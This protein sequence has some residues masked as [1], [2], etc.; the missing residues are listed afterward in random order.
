MLY[1]AAWMQSAIASC[2]AKE[3]QYT[4]PHHE[5]Q[6]YLTSPLEPFGSLSDIAI[7]KWW[8]DHCVVYP[9]LA[10]MARDFLTIPGSSTAAERQF[11]SAQHIGTDFQNRLSPDM[12]KAIQILKG[13][14]K[15]GIISTHLEASALAKVL[16]CTVNDL[17]LGDDGS[18][19][20]SL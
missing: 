1:G 10:K 15:A 14:Y 4:D 12:F 3:L 16:E 20:V 11:S 18:I 6:A 2:V 7:I 8:K 19:N 5:L 13:G 9:T 17:I